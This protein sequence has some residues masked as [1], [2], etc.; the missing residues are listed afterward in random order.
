MTSHEVM[1]L[2]LVL[3]VLAAVAIFGTQDNDPWNP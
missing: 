1:L 2:L 3:G